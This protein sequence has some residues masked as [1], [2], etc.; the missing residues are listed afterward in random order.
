MP[1][2]PLCGAAGARCRVEF[3]EDGGEHVG[4]YSVVQCGRCGV[5]F[6]SPFPSGEQLAELYGD[7]Y[8]AE[9]SAARFRVRPAEWVAQWFRGRR[10]RVLAG[11]MN[12]ATGRRVLDVGCGR[13]FTLACLQRA[14]ADVFGTQVSTAAARQ[15]ARLVGDDRIFV[16]ELADAK[17]PERW[18]DAVTLWHVLEH[19]PAPRE[20]L[21]EIERL[22]RPG[23][24]V[25]IEVP[26]A[27]GWTARTF[28]RRWL[29]YDIPR[30]L[31]HFSPATL[32]V[33]AREAGLVCRDEVQL[34]LEYSPVTLLQTLLN[35]VLGG[36][37][38]L[39]RHLTQERREA[40]PGA[41]RAVL[42]LHLAVAA[43]LAVPSLV[44]S[45]WLA[46]TRSGDTWGGYF[47]RPD[48]A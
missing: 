24:F 34:S 2:C 17:Y 23:G 26:N 32:K 38:L 10:A 3:G 45:A 30:H 25:Y 31:F 14:G 8:Y 9:A 6:T 20:L 16:G 47:Y 36:D 15:A 22:L 40:D 48:D 37:S 44:L 43:A 7:R 33:L 21:R 18:F 35:A 4:E 41:G 29:G 46:W 39:F 5:E 13:G 42:A 28:G 11:R 19:V 27:G 1:D 12:G